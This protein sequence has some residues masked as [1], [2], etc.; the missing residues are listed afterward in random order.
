VKNLQYR[1][2][3]TQVKHE[4]LARYL[5]AWG[6]IIINGLCHAKHQRVWQFVYVDC[7][8][9]KGKYAGD[10]ENIFRHD[11][12][13]GPVYG[14]PIIGL[15]ALDK[16]AAYATSLGIQVVTNTVLIEKDPANY[17]DLHDTLQECGLSG[18]IQETLKFS[19]LDNGEIAMVRDDATKLGDKLTAYTIRPG[20]WAFYLI[21]PYGPSGIPYDFVRKIVK[22]NH[23]DVMINLI[24]EDLVR[25][26]GMALNKG[27][28]PTHKQLVD[29]WKNAY[30]NALWDQIVVKTLVDIRDHCYWRDVLGGIPLD[31][32]EDTVIMTD[33]QLAEAK[34]RAFVFGYQQTLESMDPR[35]AIKLSALQFPDRDRTMFYLFLTTHDP[36]GALLINQK[37]YEAKLLEYELRYKFNTLRHIPCGQMSFWDPV[38]NVPRPPTDERPAIEIIANEI[39]RRL[40]GKILTRKGVYICLADSLFFPTE[41]DSALKLLKRQGRLLYDGSKLTHHTQMQFAAETSQLTT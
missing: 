33:E 22:G 1:S 24:Y 4:I 20:I 29:H 32:M 25:K 3:Q 39:Y 26:T 38:Q 10:Q 28:G 23:H 41:I 6:G 36:T 12:T 14:S 40:Q 21:D 13:T 30:G 31:D 5:D 18:R 17:R 19:S 35:I 2:T 27:L 37:L 34:E 8:A 7:F 11:A 15:R 16:L 9:Y